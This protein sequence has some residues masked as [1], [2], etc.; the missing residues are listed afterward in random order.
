MNGYRQE[1]STMIRVVPVRYY[2]GNISLL[3]RRNSLFPQKQGI[4]FNLLE[5]LDKN[6]KKTNIKAE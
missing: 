1:S 4:S 3:L 6:H 2:E 5:S